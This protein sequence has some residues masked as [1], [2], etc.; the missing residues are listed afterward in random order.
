MSWGEPRPVLKNFRDVVFVL[1]LFVLALF[2][3]IVMAACS[4]LHPE[5]KED[6]DRFFGDPY[7]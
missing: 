2:Y 7:E 6:L 5:T 1:G 3:G 4:L